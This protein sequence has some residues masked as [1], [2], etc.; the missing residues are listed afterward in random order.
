MR[1]L[2]AT[3]TSR[4]FGT[5][6]RAKGSL[7]RLFGSLAISEHGFLLFLI[8][9]G[10][11]VGIVFCHESGAMRFSCRLELSLTDLAGSLTL[12]LFS[13][14]GGFLL[15]A[16]LAITIDIPTLKHALLSGFA[17]GFL[18]GFTLLGAELA[19]LVGIELLHHAGAAG[20]THTRFAEAAGLTH[21]GL[22]GMTW[23]AFHPGTDGSSH[24]RHRERC[25]QSIHGSLAVGE[26]LSAF[27]LGNL[28]ILIG[29]IFFEESSLTGLSSS[30]ALCLFGFPGR[31]LCRAE[32][33]IAIGIGPL[34][35]MG[36][37]GATRALAGLAGR[38]TLGCRCS[39]GSGILSNHRQAGSKQQH[40]NSLFHMQFNRVVCESGGNLAAP[41]F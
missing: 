11:L 15:I 23:A 30:L 33:A 19:I 5:H 20:F 17:T 38:S 8:D 27:L 9:L 6:T 24:R 3:V 31:L 2:G 36:L 4:A 12:C 40:Q 34:H 16:Q 22:A 1:A 35:H 18:H 26:H 7:Q 10:V 32:L 37:A 39:G 14:P 25:L 41:H 21:A 13:F 28:T 29:V